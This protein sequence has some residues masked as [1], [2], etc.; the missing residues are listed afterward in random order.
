MFEFIVFWH[1]ISKG[2]GKVFDET[3]SSKFNLKG[4]CV[5]QK[6]LLFNF[7]IGIEVVYLVP[8]ILNELDSFLSFEFLV[9]G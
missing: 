7:F 1:I 2:V 9:V 5:F 8:Q 6:F 4:L 3:S